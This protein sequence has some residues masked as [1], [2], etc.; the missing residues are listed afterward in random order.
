MDNYT[1]SKMVFVGNAATGKTREMLHLKEIPLYSTNKYVKTIGA[2]VHPI[3]IH[4]NDNRTILFTIWDIG[5]MSLEMDSAFVNG[6]TADANVCVLFGEKTAHWQEI[7]HT[8]APNCIYHTYTT[9]ENLMSF[10]NSL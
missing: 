9:H 5:S 8:N 1:T 6:F 4:T 3:S 10:L 7:V 2:E